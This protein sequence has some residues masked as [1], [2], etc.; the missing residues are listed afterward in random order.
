MWTISISSARFADEK[1]ASLSVECPTNLVTDRDF[2]I[3]VALWCGRIRDRININGGLH[4][5]SFGFLAGE[6]V[7]E[8]SG[9]R[10]SNESRLE[11]EAGRFKVV[12]SET[13]QT[14]NEGQLAAQLGFDIGKWFG[15]AKAAAD[16]GGHLNRTVSKTEQKDGE[17]YQVFWRVADA[18]HNF[19]RVFGIGLNAESV[20]ENKIMG[21][22][23]LCYIAVDG[24]QP[25]EVLVSFRCDLRDLWFQQEDLLQ[26]TRDSRFSKE[27]DERNRHAI[28]RRVVAIALNR[29]LNQSGRELTEQSVVLARQKIR[30]EN[31]ESEVTN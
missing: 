4:K 29:T 1:L 8:P 19:W 26:L 14:K 17:Y 21:E 15:L 7:V 30:L 25:I 12:Q 9:G 11:V 5:F 6:V 10:I 22:E 3:L 13:D 31:A 18:G 23:P 27:Q 20:L 28:A 24:N 16:V 2:G